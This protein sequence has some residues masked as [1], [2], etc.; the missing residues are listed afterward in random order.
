[1]GDGHIS[2]IHG[3]NHSVEIIVILSVFSKIKVKASEE[4]N[5][6]GLWD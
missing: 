1:V 2:E 3:P 5:L 6:E 4:E